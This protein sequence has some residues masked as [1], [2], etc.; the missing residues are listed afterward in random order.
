MIGGWSAMR[1]LRPTPRN[2]WVA[3]ESPKIACLRLDVMN[4]AIEWHDS[5]LIAINTVSAHDSVIVVDAY[6]HRSV[7]TPGVSRGEGGIQ[8][9]RINMR[10]VRI[11]GDAGELPA[12]I[13]DGTL[14]LGG[15]EHR[16][17]IAFP[18]LFTGSASLALTF[19]DRVLL[20]SG[21]HISIEADGDFR[22][23]EIFDFTDDGSAN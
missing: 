14:G 12:T 5:E 3:G 1:T 13:Y 4:S 18:L 2:Y 16:N 19:L 7:E 9:V 22:F 21:E 23:I 6:V 17:L 15:E 10:S 8:R 11:E 20:V